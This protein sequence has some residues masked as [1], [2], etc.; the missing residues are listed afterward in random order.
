MEV[1]LPSGRKMEDAVDQVM[2]IYCKS[3][4]NRESEGNLIES[5]KFCMEETAEFISSQ[6]KWMSLS[7]NCSVKKKQKTMESPQSASGHPPSPQS[8]SVPSKSTG[9]DLLSD[10]RKSTGEGD[11]K[12]G[13]CG[14]TEGKGIREKKARK[15]RGV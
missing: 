6:T 7:R 13:S 15:L 12:R 1:K 2:R 10:G 8:P 14:R 4:G 9:E 11:R 3:D 5:S